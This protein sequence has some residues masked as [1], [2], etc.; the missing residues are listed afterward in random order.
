[1]AQVGKLLMTAPAEGASWSV[2]VLPY[3]KKTQ[4]SETEAASG[5]AWSGLYGFASRKKTPREGLWLFELNERFIEKPNC[6]TA[7]PKREEAREKT[8][9]SS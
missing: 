9:R 5:L 7:Y 2:Y 6:K 1:M 8:Q 4:K 3:N